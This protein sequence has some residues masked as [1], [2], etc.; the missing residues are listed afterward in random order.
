MKNEGQLLISCGSGQSLELAP[1]EV[2]GILSVSAME[3]SF[4]EAVVCA[5]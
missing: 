1:S 4:S 3:E 2:S 5:A